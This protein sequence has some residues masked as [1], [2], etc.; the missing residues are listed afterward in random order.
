MHMQPKIHGKSPKPRY[1]VFGACGPYQKAASKWIHVFVEQ[2]GPE[3]EHRLVE[4]MPFGTEFF[5]HLIMQYG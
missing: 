4:P 2:R 1:R 5:D 3:R